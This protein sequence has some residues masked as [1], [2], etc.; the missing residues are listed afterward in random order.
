MTE[1][2]LTNL[3]EETLK[4]I[5]E[6]NKTQSDIVW[7][8]SEDGQ[9]VI[10]WNEFAKIA[11]T[12]NYDSGFGC[13]VIAKDLVVLFKDDSWLERREYD[14][15][16]WWEYKRLPIKSETSKPFSTVYC[17]D[18]KLRDNGTAGWS[19]LKEYNDPNFCKEEEKIA[20]ELENVL[21][22]EVEEDET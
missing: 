3:F 21:S 7:V 16:E 9:L 18:E 12:I 17:L 2:K 22:T 19:T 13:Q 1:E 5:F 11:K 15:S 6:S 8:G 14:G 4:Q 20:K 10:T